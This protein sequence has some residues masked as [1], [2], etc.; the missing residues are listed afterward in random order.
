MRNFT[1]IIDY[2]DIVLRIKYLRRKHNI[3]QEKLAEAIDLSISHIIH[4]E[5]AST[6]ISLSSLVAIAIYFPVYWII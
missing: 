3:S 5:N 1:H 6:K 4:I 2:T